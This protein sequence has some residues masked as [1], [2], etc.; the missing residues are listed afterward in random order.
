[1][2]L[3]LYFNNHSGPW[4]KT[5]FFRGEYVWTVSDHGSNKPLRI[6]T[7]WSELPGHLN[8]AVYSQR[9]NKTYFFKGKR[10]ETG[11]LYL[12]GVVRDSVV[13]DRCV[14]LSTTHLNIVFIHFQAM[15]YGGITTSCW[16]LGIPKS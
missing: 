1:M 13:R 15:K 5:F 8:A 14:V 7:L 10:Y 11:S 4:R 2:K 6:D 16:M 3:V 12:G 9:T